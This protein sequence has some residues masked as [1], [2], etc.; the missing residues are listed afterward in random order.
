MISGGIIVSKEELITS[1]ASLFSRIRNIVVNQ[2]K[3]ELGEIS[4]YDLQHFY[5]YMSEKYEDEIQRICKEFG[6]LGECDSCTAKILTNKNKEDMIK[7]RFYVKNSIIVS[8][9]DTDCLF[10]K[11]INNQICL[12]KGPPSF[13]DFR[14]D[15]NQILLTE[16]NETL[17]Q[18]Y[19]LLEFQKASLNPQVI[20][21]NEWKIMLSMGEL[22]VFIPSSDENAINGKYAFYLTVKENKKRLICSFP[23]VAQLLVGNEDQFLHGFTIGME[24]L[25]IGLQYLF[26]QYK[27]T[28]VESPGHIHPQKETILQKIFKN[29]F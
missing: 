22:I 23:E 15:I 26:M 1:K 11:R 29:I 7:L 21:K 17:Q 19:S 27:E 2:G 24:Q 5:K 18:L 28:V 9:K 10:Y 3:Q 13:S 4:L 20:T 6:Q 16:Q 14:Y 25:P 12:V 8:F